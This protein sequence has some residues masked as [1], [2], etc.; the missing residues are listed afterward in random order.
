MTAEEACKMT[1]IGMWTCISSDIKKSIMDACNN[2]EY[3]ISVQKSS[4]NEADK[5][6][7]SKL[8]YSVTFDGTDSFDPR[9]Y[10]SW[11]Y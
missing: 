3:E 7:L 8:G 5:E 1:E 11:K 6:R 4:L 2:G 9:Y 10:I